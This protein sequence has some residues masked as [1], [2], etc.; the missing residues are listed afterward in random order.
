MTGAA[1]DGNAASGPARLLPVLAFLGA[2][3]MGAAFFLHVRYFNDDSLITLRCATNLSNGE[4]LVYNAGEKILGVT[5]PLWALLLAAAVKL[6][7]DGIAAATWL[8]VAAFGWSASAAVLLLR[9]RGVA[10]PGQALVAALFASSPMLLSWAG[11][12]METPAYVAAIVTFLWLLETRSFVALGFVGGAMILLRPDAGLVLAACA[13]VEVIRTREI[14]PLL[15]AA[16]GF[17]LL[18]LPWVVV[19][20]IYYGSPLPNSGFAKRLQVEDWGTY[21]GALGPALWAVGAVLPF[22]LVGFVASMS[23]AVRAGGANGAGSAAPAASALAIAAGMHFGGLPGC[24]WYLPPVMCLVLVLAAEG[25]SIA[26]SAVA[27]G[28][29]FLRKPIA[30]AIVASPLIGHAKL[31]AVA[32]DL[33]ISQSQIE[34]C[35][36][37]VGTWLGEH[38]PRGVSVGVDNIGYIG[39]RS[40]LRVVDMLGLVQGGTR[41]RI[42]AGERDYALR[43]QRPELIACWI[44]RGSTHKYLPPKSWFES[45]GYRVVFEA[46]LHD[47]SPQPAYTVFSR[48]EGLR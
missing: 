37:K 27:G 26:A 24:G 33:K 29:D 39:W 34:R 20:T 19:G 11:A 28:A 40:G 12:G 16:P 4:G 47:G 21:L 44:G 18:V 7:I 15:R 1:P 38:A 46:P 36:G 31:P 48:I 17:A 3:A 43:S 5:T 22:A 6:G 23:R 9:A 45:E 2:A 10:W 25:A 35:H 32:H 14:R 41:E 30:L 42:A 13:V 8:G